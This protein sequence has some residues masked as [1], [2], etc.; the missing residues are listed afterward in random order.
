MDLSPLHG[1]DLLE[2]NSGDPGGRIGPTL[3]G[4]KPDVRNLKLQFV[5]CDE[6]D[7]CF[8]CSSGVA[9]NFDPQEMDVQPKAIDNTL[10]VDK[11]SD[12]IGDL[13]RASDVKN[14]YRTKKMEEILKKQE[15]DITAEQVSTALIDYCV[16]LTLAMRD[17]MQQNPGTKQ[18]RDKSKYPGRFSHVTAVCCRVGKV[19]QLSKSKLLLLTSKKK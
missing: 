5:E 13:G 14:T 16:N 17:F 9:M 11:W 15:G 6:G 12:L 18:P 10:A 4:G 2:F 8:L 3:D 7:I 1:S 19:P